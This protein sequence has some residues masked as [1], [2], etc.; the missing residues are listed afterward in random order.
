[1]FIT[2]ST[3]AYHWSLSWVRRMQSALYKPISHLHLGLPSGVFPSGSPT[4]TL[5]A[6][7]IPPMCATC[8]AQLILLD[9]IWWSQ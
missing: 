3:R 4:T 9:L 1:M 8:S 5:Y 6:F 2:V 7:I